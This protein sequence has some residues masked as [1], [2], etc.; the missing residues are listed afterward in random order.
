MLLYR[1]KIQHF[2]IKGIPMNLTE[3]KNV[4]AIFE[5][6]SLASLS[7][8]EKDK[9][10]KLKKQGA[11]TQ[12]PVVTSTK[13]EQAPKEI[14]DD[15]HVITA[16][17][18][19]TFYEAPSPEADPFVKKGQKISKGDKLCILEAMKIFNEIEAD[20][21]CTILEVLVKDGQVVEY[22]SP[23]FRVEKR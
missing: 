5:K 22:D 19:G 16:P 4:I 7:Y 11:Q 18:V 3:L 23:L 20:F 1:T 21:D 6:S 13:K 9:T 12:A 14:V 17:M 15:A 8:T 2:F 10:I